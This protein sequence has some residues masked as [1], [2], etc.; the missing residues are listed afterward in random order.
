[1]LIVGIERAWPQSPTPLRLPQSHLSPLPPLSCSHTGATSKCADVEQ[2]CRLF[3][4]VSA[5]YGPLPSPILEGLI[6]RLCAPV[7]DLLA[8]VVFGAATERQRKK[9]TAE[10]GQLLGRG[11]AVR[12]AIIG[13]AA[14]VPPTAS[15]LAAATLVLDYLTAN[16]C[17]IYLILRF[18]SCCAVVVCYACDVVVF[19]RVA[20]CDCVSCEEA[21]PQFYL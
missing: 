20:V 5:F 18:L 12:D 13:A 3:R 19:L 8:T 10:F 16:G 15:S 6:A 21:S 17:G 2:A 7:L 4:V 11:G 9:V 1:M 14:A